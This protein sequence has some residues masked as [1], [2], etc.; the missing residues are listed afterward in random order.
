MNNIENNDSHK[1]FCTLILYITA[2]I[3]MFLTVS[4]M[5]HLGSSAGLTMA[6]VFAL[7]GCV[8][9]IVKSYSPTLISKVIGKGQAT[10]I[11]LGV[12]S[13]T[14][15]SI[16]VAAS[17]FSL[18]NGINAALSQT[19][20]SQA[21]QLRI[22]SLK[23]DIADLVALQKKQLSVNQISKANM[24]IATLAQKRSE[25]SNIAQQAATVSNN[26]LLASFSTPIILAISIALEVI[27]IAM[28]LCLYHLSRKEGG[29]SSEVIAKEPISTHL[30][31]Q[32][33]FETQET[34]V[35][36]QS[37]TR[38]TSTTSVSNH[39]QYK[40]TPPDKKIIENMKT[41]LIK[42]ECV[43]T[44]RSLYNAFRGVV[45][46]K[47]IKKYLCELAQREVIKEGH[48]GCY[49]LA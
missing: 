16:S 31:A 43:P 22:E 38:Q 10:V 49:T 26:S 45:R 20:V 5:Y 25:L 40:S 47:E 28:T 9:D 23:N 39:S 8:F 44:H 14:L 4:F 17:V 41:A 46:Q 36:T 33:R 7:I 34:H 42:G 2:G 1:A 19:K 13:A 21:T 27:S 30:Q 32:T 3:S 11:L 12:I 48:N 37:K 6:I 24:T 35:Y 15:V 18:Q 29:Q